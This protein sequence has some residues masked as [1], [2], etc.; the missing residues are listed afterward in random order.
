MLV[1]INMDHT[2]KNKN[3]FIYKMELDNI[4]N[5]EEIW[6]YVLLYSNSVEFVFP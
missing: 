5:I 4:K 1:F 6:Y 3:I 2:L